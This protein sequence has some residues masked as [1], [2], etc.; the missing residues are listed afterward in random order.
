[1][2]II[3]LS[4]KR[5]IPINIVKSFFLHK[6]CLIAFT[7]AFLLSEPL[8][9]KDSNDS[10]THS[11]H[12]HGY[13]ELTIALDGDLLEINFESPAINI[14]GFEY[15]AKSTKEIQ[16][17]EKSEALLKA[18]ERIFSF[19]GTHCELKNLEVN[20]ENS[21][22]PDKASRGIEH[23]GHVER[24]Y[25]EEHH[26]HREH[27]EHEEHHD[28]EKQHSE[29]SSNYLYE[30]DAGENLTVIN[31]KLIRYF[32]AIEKLKVMWVN[33]ERQGAMDLTESSEA[34][35]IR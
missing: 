28:R 35:I 32:P 30:C 8:V 18:A 12:L 24:H 5:V 25:Q 29:I 22:D 33:N 11:T 15:K 9:A 4:L 2:K 16:R 17:L 6:I 21:A 13:A 7:H 31:V 3:F 34:V 1:M 10:V 27:E 26:E 20:I 19:N 14:V 23:E